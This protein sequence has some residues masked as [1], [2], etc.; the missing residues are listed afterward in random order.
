MTL[1]NFLYLASGVVLGVLVCFV[2]L[3]LYVVTRPD[4]FEDWEYI[5]GLRDGAA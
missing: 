4:H 3:T 2:A 5:D 1:T